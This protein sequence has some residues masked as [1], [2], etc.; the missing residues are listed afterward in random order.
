MKN[1][2]TPP[3]YHVGVTEDVARRLDTH[4]AGGCAHTAADRPW[5]RHV[6]IEF[7]KADTQA[8]LTKV[9]C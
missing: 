5:A 6:V 4:N 7:A 8:T 9:A 1:P 3:Q 2:E